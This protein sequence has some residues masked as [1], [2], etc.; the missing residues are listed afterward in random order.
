MA[1]RY[2]ICSFPR[3]SHS[4]ICFSLLALHCSIRSQT[5]LC[6]YAHS[7]ARSLIHSGFKLLM[8]MNW[9]LHFHR[10][11]THCA[12]LSSSTH[13][14]EK[15]EKTRRT[16][17]NPDT[18]KNE[19]REKDGW[20][21]DSGHSENGTKKSTVPRARERVNERASEQTSE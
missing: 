15:Q 12:M 21:S 5:I 17:Q 11:S 2:S 7:L 14:A 20:L 1:I 18:M 8:S 9:L 16:K 19:E 3:T 10:V 13:E 4:I 6:S